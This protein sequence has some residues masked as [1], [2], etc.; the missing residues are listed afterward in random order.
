MGQ[1]GAGEGLSGAMPEGASDL[2][3]QV[4]A[5][6]ADQVSAFFEDLFSADNIMA[7]FARAM[8]T[9]Y[10]FSII[11]VAAG[12]LLALAVKGRVKRRAERVAPVEEDGGE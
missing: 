12:A 9:T 6:V 1:M 10:L 8:R 4:P 2:L 7:E 3:G 11:L 5:S